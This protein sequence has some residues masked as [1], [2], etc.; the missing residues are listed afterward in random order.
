MR[1]KRKNGLE[2]NVKRKINDLELDI[3]EKKLI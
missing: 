3:K 1:R 2:L